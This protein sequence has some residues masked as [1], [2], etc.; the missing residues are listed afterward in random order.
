MGDSRLPER[1]DAPAKASLRKPETSAKPDLRNAEQRQAHQAVI[2][3][4]LEDAL[5]LMGKT[6]LKEQAVFFN[7]D[8]R[9]VARWINGTEVFRFADVWAIEAL[10][11]FLVAALAESCRRDLVE[12]EMVIR[13]RARRK[14]AA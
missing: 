5:V 13:V 2:G 12:I 4:I 9:Q 1:A 3:E 7:R 10:Q 14:A 6:R 8:E 11:P